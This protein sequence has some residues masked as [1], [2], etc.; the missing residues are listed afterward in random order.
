MGSGHYNIIVTNPDGRSDI[1]QNAFTVGD[2]APTILSIT[3]NTA[4]L[5]DL[6]DSF[7]INGQ[8][9][10]TSGVKVTFVQAS[11]EIDCTSATAIDSTKVTCGPVPFK[12]TNGAVIGTWDVKVLNIDGSQSGT[13]S[14]GFTLLNVTTTTS[15]S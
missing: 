15:S 10:K 2:A 6:V 1:L 8:N 3:P 5:G 12:T 14:Q 13:M 4:E 11:T 9:F 7:T